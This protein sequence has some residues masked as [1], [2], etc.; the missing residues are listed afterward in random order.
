MVWVIWKRELIRFIRQPSRIIAAIGTPVLIW[1]FLGSGFSNSISFS[2]GEAGGAGAISAAG[3]SYSVYLLPGMMT[4]IA[5]F[6]AIFAS[7]SIIEDRKDGWLQSVL[8][9]PCPRAAIAAGKILGGTTIAFVQSVVLLAALPLLGD[10]PGA[11]GVACT[12]IALA[13]TCIAMTGVG[14]AFAWVSETT[15]GFHAVMNLVLMPLWF[16]SGAFF[17]VE[18]S[19]IWLGWIMRANLLTWCTMSIRAP[20]GVEQAEWSITSPT[21][22]GALAVTFAFALGAFIVA[23]MVIARPTKRAAS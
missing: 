2:G 18:G 17:P 10:R 6:T 1:I 12:I 9:S 16:L 11:I 5:M 22:L 15:Q 20:I 4:L 7:I 8:V 23:T 3:P 14:V 21:W 19:A 13:L